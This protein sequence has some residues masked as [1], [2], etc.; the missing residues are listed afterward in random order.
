MVNI[1]EAA[2]NLVKD[3]FTCFY[4]GKISAKSIG[5]IDMYFVEKEV[6]K[7]VTQLKTEL[8][9]QSAILQTIKTGYSEPDSILS[10]DPESSGI[11]YNDN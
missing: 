11:I 10:P 6:E 5:E 4:R 3:Q 9:L 2:Y 8:S 1:S 7:D